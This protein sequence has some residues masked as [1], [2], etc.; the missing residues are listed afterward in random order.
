MAA[1]PTPSAATFALTPLP[2]SKVAINRAVTTD[3][4]Q[5]FLGM[6]QTDT[7]IIAAL[8]IPGGE[9]KN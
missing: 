8:M 2:P 9:F 5:G 3:Q 4:R 7:I 6:E 1:E